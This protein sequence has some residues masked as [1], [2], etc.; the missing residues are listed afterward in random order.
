MFVSESL[1]VCERERECVC[2]YVRESMCVCVCTCAA[3]VSHKRN[4][5]FIFYHWYLGTVFL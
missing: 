4:V 1:C 5:M 3:V 2:L